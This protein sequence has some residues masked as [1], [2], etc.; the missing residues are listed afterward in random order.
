MTLIK[1]I[2]ADKKN[3]F[4]QFSIPNCPFSPRWSSSGHDKDIHDN[5]IAGRLD[6]NQYTEG[7]ITPPC[8]ARKSK[9]PS[10]SSPQ[11]SILNPQL[12]I[13]CPSVPLF[14]KNLCFSL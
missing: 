13:L 2:Y 14:L 3:C 10:G 8:A 6:F 12:S 5:E 7:G 4:P 11:V 1:L 9:A